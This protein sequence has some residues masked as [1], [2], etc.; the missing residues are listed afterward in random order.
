M[1]QIVA[2]WGL[3]TM[4]YG[5]VAFAQTKQINKKNQMASFINKG[6]AAPKEWFTGTVW[7]NMNVTPD[8]GY[9]ANIATVTFERQARTNWHS[10]R[11]GQ[12]LFVIEGIGYY[13]EKGQPMRVIREGDV[14][15]I[16]KNVVH[17]H[18]ASHQNSMRH[19]A[20]I[21]DVDKDKTEWF[22]P[23]SDTDYNQA[24]SNN[25]TQPNAKALANHRQ[26][27]PDYISKVQQTDPDLV[28]VFDNFAFDE[29]ISHDTTDVKRRTLLIMA[30]TIGSQALTEY[31]M[32]VNAALNV[33]VRPTEIKEVVYQAVPYV[34]VAK[35]IDFIAATND[36]FKERNIALP[37][38][39][40]ATT[41]PENRQEKGLALQK[42]I[43]GSRID[44]MYK[45]SPK[46]LL[47]IQQYLSANCFGDYVTRS[48]LDIPTRELVTLAFL[49]ALGGAEGQIKGHIQ[50]NANVGNDRQTIIN[51]LTQLLPYVGYPRTLNAINCLNEVLPAK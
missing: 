1:K 11:S 33:G 17:W 6:N 16:P 28:A 34:G 9:N 13:Q 22:E 23:V 15:K 18:G 35:V 49:V 48:G 37:L 19:I 45:N 8:E 41:T 3:V 40:H 39:S 50:G 27:W 44:D 5:G 26:L 10:H 31:R 46:D 29:V 51:L 42:Q 43:F 21:T 2:F 20:M 14:V 7:V 4:L 24:Q 12:L 38:E 47:H 30:S 32:F 36:I 25:G